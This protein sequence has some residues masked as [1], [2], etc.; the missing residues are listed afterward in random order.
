ML[1]E[2]CFSKWLTADSVPGLGRWRH[3]VED[4]NRHIERLNKLGAEYPNDTPSPSYLLLGFSG[5]TP[6]HVLV[7]W[8]DDSSDCYVVTTYI[9]SRDIWNEEYRTRRG[10]GTM[11]CVICKTGETAQGTTTVFLNRGDTS[12]ILKQVP[13]DI[14]ENCGEYYLSKEITRQVLEKAEAAATKGVEI[15]VCRYAA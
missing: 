8:N 15:E 5:S 13:A 9:P 14:C 7:A 1:P 3:A 6:L 2:M 10:G 4:H 11:K 12:V